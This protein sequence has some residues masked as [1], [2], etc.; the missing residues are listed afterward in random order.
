VLRCLQA[1]HKCAL[2]AASVDHGLRADAVA[3]VEVARKLAAGLGIPFVALRAHVA[4]GAS[5]QAEARRAR[6]AVLEACAR[7]HDAQRI[8]TGHTLDDQAETVLSRMLRGTGVDGLSGVNPARPD[9]VIRP[10][11]DCERSVVHAYVAE[12]DLQFVR[13]PSNENER[14]L[15]TRIRHDIL[16]MLAALNPRIHVALA[17][18]AD[19]ARDISALMNEQCDALLGTQAPLAEVLA[20][21]ESSL[22]RRWT[23][24]RWARS[25]EGIVLLRTHL[26]ALERMLTR[27]GRVRLPGDFVASRGN[28]GE[29][30]LEPV[31]KRGRGEQRRNTRDKQ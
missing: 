11:I 4:A 3:D 13:D 31:S 27:G 28:S 30:L 14:F 18:L 2:I 24:R 17:A 10:L 1:E 19:D 9:G 21:E 7:S 23:L 12:H 15:R 25:R 29:L 8:A 6:Y 5:L 20:R 22:R 26:D 16:P